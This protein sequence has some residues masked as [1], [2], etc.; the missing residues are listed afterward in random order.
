MPPHGAVRGWPCSCQPHDDID[1]HSPMSVFYR[2]WD[3][4]A[5]AHIVGITEHPGHGAH[6]PGTHNGSV[7]NVHT[8]VAT[9]VE[10]F[11]NGKPPLL[12][13]DQGDWY[14]DCDDDD[15]AYWIDKNPFEAWI[16]GKSAAVQDIFM[17]RLDHSGGTA[18]LTNGGSGDL[19]IGLFKKTP[20]PH[21]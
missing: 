16:E 7:L 12:E 9:A 10:S 1:T 20:E 17:L 8:M 6:P 15:F 14:C 3:E 2:A 21:G 4:G 18:K 11:I 5:T 13:G 19:F